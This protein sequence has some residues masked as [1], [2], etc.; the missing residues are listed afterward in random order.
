L[1]GAVLCLTV[2][3]AC[4]GPIKPVPT[5][6]SQEAPPSSTEPADARKSPEPASSEAP[7]PVVPPV[8][9][10]LPSQADAPIPAEGDVPVLEA[11][12]VHVMAQRESYKVDQATTATRTDT[13][14]MDTPFSVQVVP[15]QV[16]KDQQSVRLDTAL[17][18][19]SGV[20]ANQSL[21]LFE[22][23]NLR[24]FET[25]DHYREGVRFQ[26]ALSQAG[27]REMA[28]L[29]RIEVLKGPASIL[30]GRIQPGGMINLVTK[31]PQADSYYSIQQQVGSYDFYRT[32][33]DATSK[34]NESGSLLY[35]FNMSYENS[36]SFR[37]FA[38]NDRAFFAPV[39]QWNLS[40]RTQITFDVEYS[41]GKVR[42]DYGTVAVGNRPAVLPIERNLGES[43]ANAAYEAIL[44]G[45]NLTHEFNS[46]WKFQHRVY[47]Q[48]STENDQVVSPLGLQ[49]DNRTLD[50]FFSGFQGNKHKTY[51]TNLDLT[52]HVDTWGA[53]HTLLVGADYY[54]FNN[55][56]TIV[57]NFAFPSIDIF[58]PIRGGAAIRDPADDFRFEL[59]EHWVGLY[60]QDQVELPFHLHLLAGVRYDNAEIESSNTFGGAQTF[61]RSRQDRFTPRLGLLWQPVKEVAL[62]GN[63]V[64]GF[65]VPNLGSLGVDG[66]S[67]KA[68]T[69][70]QWEA[71]I[72]TELF[73][74]RWRASAA[75]FDLTKQNI[76]TGHP[77][78]VL[79]ALGFFVQTGEARN[80]G[81]EVDLSGELLPGLDM[82]A[83]YAYTNSE[84]TQSNDGTQGHR[85][86]NVP[87][88][89]G[90]LWMTYQFQ[91]QTLKG[92]KLGGGLLARGA[93]EGNRENDF[94]MQGY[95]L[96][97]LMT[98]Y[99]MPLGR[100]R[101]TAQLNVDNLLGQEYFPSS[102][103]FGRAR[104]DVGTP[105]FFMGSIRM[106]F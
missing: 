56:G 59:K 81:I 38:Q 89:A 71:G 1:L 13:P 48:S 101:L 104:I 90:S 5:Q 79:A 19:I 60:L 8:P 106:E 21:S 62:Y 35:R 98:S 64:E 99:T 26:S 39:V 16:M 94:Q 27:R 53:T 97:N 49:A 50:R 70:Q 77:D 23:Y 47:V 42:P 63:Y 4:I 2:F 15:A 54:H 24:G 22:S 72:K 105:R 82:I 12:P 91:E 43:F 69:S 92:W 17:N 66:A 40:N 33:F 7:Q 57:D 68:E 14:I 93:R 67:L 45:Y 102:A 103:G 74:G 20:Y 96:V 28:N 25:F 36:G 37:E 61:Q 52:G 73:D 88:H 29:E 11:K 31:K 80:K 51:S 100:T 55:T 78:P 76:A 86:P 44:A 84:I 85:F 10:P 9:L 3:T 95:V 87:K 65:G 75:Y 6:Q 32:A 58:S 34:L 18:N 46:R 41:K 30:Y 83:N